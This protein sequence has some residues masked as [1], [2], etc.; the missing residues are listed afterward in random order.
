MQ[1]YH[2][3]REMVRSLSKSSEIPKW[4]TEMGTERSRIAV[5][6]LRQTDWKMPTLI[7]AAS[8]SVVAVNSQRQSTLGY[9]GTP[10]PMFVMHTWRKWISR[11]Q[12]TGWPSF[13]GAAG[14]KEAGPCRI[15]C[16][17]GCHFL[18]QIRAQNGNK[19]E[20]MRSDTY[21]YRHSTP[22]LFFPW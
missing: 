4:K 21:D 20:L 10:R 11:R 9:V 15:T 17:C 19:A 1:Y 2:T 6:R 13:Q 8:T 3:L 14:L 12:V 7:L 22:R 18:R 5:P 16:S